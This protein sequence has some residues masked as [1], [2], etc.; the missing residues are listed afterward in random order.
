[1][2]RLGRI[3]MA[4]GNAGKLQEIARLLSGLG[5]EVIAQSALG[6]G[7]VDETGTTFA[8]NSLQKAQH[9][10]AMTG[11]PAIADDSGLAVDALGGRP[12]VFSAR[13]SGPGATDA[14]NID[15][16]L[17]ELADVADERRSAAFHCVATFVAP[18]LDEPIVAQGIWRG[19]ILRARRGSGGFG[20]DPVFL[21][22]VS[23]KSA[24][25][26]AA[27]EKNARSH[28]GQA[29]R[30]LTALLEQRYR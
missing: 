25:E 2:A 28:R 20:Y 1:M 27:A 8:E 10:M 26:L 21:D 30:E 18:D 12:G 7:D 23:G 14:R 16:L 4:S 29:L 13:Y 24:A 9:A 3:V 11:L 15:K 22:P 5:T 17:E 6:V 19:S